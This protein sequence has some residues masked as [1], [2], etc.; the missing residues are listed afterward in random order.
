MTCPYTNTARHVVASSLA[1]INRV[2]ASGQALYW[3]LKIQE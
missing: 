2:P 3:A 1:N